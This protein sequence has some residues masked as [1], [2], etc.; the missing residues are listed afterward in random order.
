MLNKFQ[1]LWKTNKKSFFEILSRWKS[2]LIVWY[3]LNCKTAIHL[4]WLSEMC[5]QLRKSFKVGTASFC[6]TLH[7][8]WFLYI[9]LNL[10]YA[11]S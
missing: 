2:K 11:D 9:I 3:T 4:I 8:I 6:P 7:I 1:I 5:T 10:K